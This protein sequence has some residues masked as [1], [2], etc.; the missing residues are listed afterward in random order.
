MASKTCRGSNR[1]MKGCPDVFRDGGY[2]GIGWSG[3]RIM[4]PKSGILPPTKPA[5]PPGRTEDHKRCKDI[6]G[7]YAPRLV[8]RHGSGG[9]KGRRSRTHAAGAHRGG[10]VGDRRRRMW[11]V[12]GRCNRAAIGDMRNV[13][14]GFIGHTDHAFMDSDRDGR[15]PIPVGV[16]YETFVK[17][18]KALHQ[19]GADSKPIAPD[20]LAGLMSINRHTVRGN[21]VFLASVGMAKRKKP[22]LYR[23]TA[24]GIKYAKAHV[25]GDAKAIK[26]SSLDMIKKSHLRSLLDMLDT[27]SPEQGEIYAW[28]KAKGR[29][30]DGRGTGGMHPPP[31]RGPERCCAYSPMPAWYPSRWPAN[32]DRY[33]ANQRRR[34]E[35]GK[36]AVRRPRPARRR[37][38]HGI[39]RPSE[40]PPLIT[41]PPPPPPQARRRDPHGI[42]RPWAGYP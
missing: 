17:I 33:N 5:A 41:P 18:P 2:G 6:A 30:P 25:A 19:Q 4:L 39:R 9:D 1:R 7:I 37:D 23:L 11:G 38:P 8:P 22:R 42:R 27:G 34:K 29:Y 28:I 24:R 40:P 32:P 13:V 3:A 31:V 20:K 36:D 12:G 10:A 14:N 15:W 16:K 26:R 35:N 21:L